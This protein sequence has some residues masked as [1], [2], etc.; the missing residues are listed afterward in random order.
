MKYETSNAIRITKKV[1]PT[2]TI[3]VNWFSES[4]VGCASFSIASKLSTELDETW[5]NSEGIVKHKAGD[6]GLLIL[7]PFAM[8]L[9]AQTWKV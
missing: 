2:K 8:V 6:K 3:P 4:F 5:D 7:S 1:I 9:R